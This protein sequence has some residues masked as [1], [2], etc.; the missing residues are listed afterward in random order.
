MVCNGV[1]HSRNDLKPGRALRPAVAVTAV[2]VTAGR[3]DLKPGRAL[4]PFAVEFLPVSE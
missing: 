2:P 4:R 1:V 3:N